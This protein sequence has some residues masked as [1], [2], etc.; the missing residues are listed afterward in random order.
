MVQQRSMRNPSGAKA[1]RLCLE[2][3]SEAICCEIT[4]EKAIIVPSTE[5]DDE[6]IGADAFAPPGFHLDRHSVVRFPGSMN[7]PG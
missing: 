1:K 4:R 7:N 5:H 3:A 6:T 2:A